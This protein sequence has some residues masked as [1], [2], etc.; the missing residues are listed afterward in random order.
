M[1]AAAQ[2]S[3]RVASD[4]ELLRGRGSALIAGSKPLI[5]TS[6]DNNRLAASSGVRLKRFFH[7]VI[8][9]VIGAISVDEYALKA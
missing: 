6:I 5:G 4:S 1:D 3:I 2:L 9:V 8:H 7:V